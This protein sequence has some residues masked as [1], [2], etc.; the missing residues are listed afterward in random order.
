MCQ[1]LKTLAEVFVR[2]RGMK[3]RVKYPTA[4]WDRATEMCKQHPVQKVASSLHVCTDSL[5]RHLSLRKKTGKSISP[6]VPIEIAP[7][8]SIQL[9]VSGPLS[10]TIDFNRSTEEPAKLILAMQGE[11][12]C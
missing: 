5:R 6:F 7:Q 11:V 9:H 2:Y 4:L 12:P 8:P 3:K 1:E 10:M